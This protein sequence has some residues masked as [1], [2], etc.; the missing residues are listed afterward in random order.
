MNRVHSEK[1]SRDGDRPFRAQPKATWVLLAALTGIAIYLCWR[2]LQPLA[3]VI[4]WSTV[5][6]MMFAPLNRKLLARTRRPNLSAAVTL[7][8]AVVA[9]LLPVAGLSLAVVGEVSDLLVEAP[10]KWNEWVGDPLLQ[11]RAAEWRADL[12]ERFPFVERLDA[13]RIKESLTQLGGTMVK[14]SVGLVG[15]LLQALLEFVFIVFSLF[16]LLRDAVK[17][18]SVLRRLLPLSPRQSDRLIARTVEVVHASVLGVL[19]IAFLQGALGGAMF[20]ILGLPSPILWG[21]VMALFAMIPMVGA[22]VIWLPTAIL[23]LATG[24]TGK[25]IALCAVGALVISTIDNF[26]RPR[27]VGGRT[28][29]HELVV[30]FAVLGGLKVFGVVG[31]LVGPA[32]FAVAW[33]LL[34][35]F[36]DSALER[37]EEADGVVEAPSSPPTPSESAPG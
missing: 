34:E 8:V 5:L 27:L 15:G 22:G 10:E 17:F 7:A 14:R 16:F 29:L 35:L 36:R 20:A 11:A 2:I 26:L 13:E 12:G 25:A 3:T 33:S 37:E 24:H 31:L 23:L 6:A 21:V 9:V 32:V 19:A 18:E 4:L 30:F 28:G 1:V